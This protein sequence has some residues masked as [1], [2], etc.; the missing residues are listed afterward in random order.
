MINYNINETHD[1]NFNDPDA[2]I[3]IFW[4]SFKESMFNFYNFL[5]SNNDIDNSHIINI[6]DVNNKII[7]W[8][9]ELNF[10]KNEKRYSEIESNIQTYISL[11]GLDLIKYSNLLY[12]DSILVANIRRW[13]KI[14][15]IYNFNNSNSNIDNIIRIKFFLIFFTLKEHGI[16]Y[17]DIDFFKN[18]DK[19]FINNNYDDFIVYSFIYN[20]PKILELLKDI[21]PKKL[22][23]DVKRLFPTLK[24]NITSKMVKNCQIYN[25]N[26]FSK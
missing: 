8:S 16:S 13:D 3:E 19:I 4:Y 1:I 24:F 5:K 6:D 23:N 15:N 7:K 17:E 10:L 12:H 11:Y 26:I 18:Y 14:S 25:K 2:H 9:E 21:N 22:E 20:K